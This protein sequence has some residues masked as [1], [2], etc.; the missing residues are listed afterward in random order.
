MIDIRV[1][2]SARAEVSA[3]RRYYQQE[4]QLGD[5]FLAEVEHAIDGLRQMP[6]RYPEVRPAVR[7]VLVRRFPYAVYFRIFEGK[8]LVVLA[9]L[10]QHRGPDVI[11]RKTR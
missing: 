4:A 10:H 8:S 5:A 6:T 1:R 11:S 9:V 2:P 7:R 3:A